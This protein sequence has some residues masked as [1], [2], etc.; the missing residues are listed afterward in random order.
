[1]SVE[2]TKLDSGL[3]IAT[4]SMSHLESAAIGVWA[5]VGARDED[6][7]VLGISHFLEHMAFKGTTSRSALEIVEQ[8]EQV[9]GYLN[10]YTA[11]EQTAYYA[12]ILKGDLPLA[13]DILADI[14]THSTFAESELERERGVITQEIG[15]CAD[16]PED[17]I[18]DHLQLA[19]YPDQPMGRPI[20]GTLDTVNAMSRE[21]L[22]AHVASF[23]HPG[24]L[25]LVGAGGIAHEDVVRLGEQAFADLPQ[26]GQ[27]PTAAPGNWV[28]GAKVDT[29]ELEQAHITMGFPGV[30]VHDDDFYTAQVFSEILG[31]SMSSRLFQEVREKRGLCY[32]IYSFKASYADCGMFGIYAG[33]GGESVG[34][35]IPVIAGEIEKLTAS[36]TDAEIGRSRAQAKA[37][38]LMSLESPH[39]RCEWMAKHLPRYG[40]V[41]TADELVAKVEAVDSAAIRRYATKLMETK[42]PALAALGPT[43][44]LESYDKVAA[45]FGG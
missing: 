5:S 40:R 20:L 24:S 22:Q 17:L 12:R 25:W 6:P 8:I 43:Q 16:N 44:Q 30:S 28:G 45:R 19:A 21:H 11:R 33:T 4:D 18:F 3:T 37:G 38:V 34:E 35:L 10:A 1:M 27:S 9:G 13:I 32:S 7:S 2:V 15:Q 42:H 41:L 36:V 14:L 31:G 23:Y 29:R 26:A 39:S